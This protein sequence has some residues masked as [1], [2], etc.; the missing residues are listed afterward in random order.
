MI[1]NCKSDTIALL[2]I[3]AVVTLR[4]Q[5]PMPLVLLEEASLAFGHVPLLDHASFALENG[6]RVALIGR[7]GSGKTSLLKVVAERQSLDDGNVWRAPALRIALVEQEP[8]LAPQQTV[9]EAVSA[10][11]GTL[12]QTLLE[13]HQLSQ[14][15]TANPSA[16]ELDRLHE[17]QHALEHADGWRINSRIEAAIARLGLDAEARVAELSGGTRKRVALAQAL[18]A[19]PDL[20]MLDEPT[21]HLDIESIEWLE[22]MLVEFRG[23]VLFVTHD[24][25]FL[26]TVATRII[27]LDRGRLASFPGRNTPFPGKTSRSRP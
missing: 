14:R 12:Q 3:F 8:Q 27:E 7:N 10:G 2:R 21:N 17:L 6:E 22:N 15:L 19:D 23:C 5:I 24:R 11:L 13:Y 26:D 16:V 1:C 20:L 18:A 9:F 25:R 4:P